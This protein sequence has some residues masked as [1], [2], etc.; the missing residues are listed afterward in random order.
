M[1]KEEQIIK[2]LKG[3]FSYEEM[4]DFQKT[5]DFKEIEKIDKYIAHFKAPEYDLDKGKSKLLKS[6]PHK[7]AQRAMSLSTIIKIAASTIIVLG[8]TF[9]FLKPKN[10]TRTISSSNI[11]EFLPDSSYFMLNKESMVSF[12]PKNWES[13]RALKL[14]GEAYFQV[15]DGSKFSVETSL[16]IVSVLG[17][18]FNIKSRSNYLEVVC[19]EGRVQL[20]STAINKVLERGDMIQII[21]GNISELTINKLKPL[22]VDGESSFKSV[23]LRLVIQEFERQ[24]KVQVQTGSVPIEKLF[25]GTFANNNIDLAIKSIT[26]PMNLSYEIREG[27]VILSG[28]SGE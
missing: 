25:S 14:S 24:Y 11:S 17:T 1:K 22:W 20:S 7:K 16:G 6:R 9:F 15:N 3:E 28:D 26:I 27:L 12:L 4:R 5:D 2:W 18:E 23:P 10:E 13:D 8:V 21:D 19:Y